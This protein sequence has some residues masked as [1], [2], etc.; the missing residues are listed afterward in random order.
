MERKKS[1]M[2]KKPHMQ[3]CYSGKEYD[4]FKKLKDQ[5][6]SSNLV[7]TQQKRGSKDW[8]V[9]QDKAEEIDKS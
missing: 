6:T 7:G 5:A 8:I 4:V 3:K 9:V 1:T 2:K